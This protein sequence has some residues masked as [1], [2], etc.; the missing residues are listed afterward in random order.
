VAQPAPR[1][2]YPVV[3]IDAIY[4]KVRDGQ[5][6]NR[7][8]Y[9]AIGV[10]VEGKRDILGVW[11]SS[12]SEGAKYWLGVLT[13]IR[14]RG[15]AD[16]CI[17]VCDGLKGLPEAVAATWPLTI[18]QTCVLHLIRNT[19][20]LASRAH[21]CRSTTGTPWPRTSGRSTPLRRRRRPRNAS[22]SSATSGL[23]ATRPSA[24]YNDPEFRCRE[25]EFAAQ[26]E[27]AYELSVANWK[28]KKPSRTG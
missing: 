15:V 5:V 24:A 8:V 21:W 10:T 7:A 25:R 3:F 11:A 4:V 23:S 19:F 18:V 27:R 14:N 28:D 17:L 13:E 16:V 12:G 2:V 1:A 26:Q 22:S 6:S 9:C 20:R